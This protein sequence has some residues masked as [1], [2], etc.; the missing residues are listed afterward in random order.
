MI[1]GNLV[2]YAAG[3][4]VLAATTGMGL[5]DAVT[6]GALVFLPW[7]LAKVIAA[8]LLLPYVWRVAGR[9]E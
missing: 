9:W 8:S 2:I 7:D 1:L 5:G 4:P 3:I 6:K